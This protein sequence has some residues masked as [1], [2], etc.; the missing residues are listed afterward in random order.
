MRGRSTLTVRLWTVGGSEACTS[1]TFFTKAGTLK[2]APLFPLLPLLPSAG[3][4][5]G[6]LEKG[7][8]AL[9]N[10]GREGREGCCIPRQVCGAR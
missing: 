7:G 3:T 2:A 8:G 6:I 10:L 9:A 5:G 4:S 1:C